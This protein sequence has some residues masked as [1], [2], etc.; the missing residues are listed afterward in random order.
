MSHLGGSL[1]YD[2]VAVSVLVTVVLLTDGSVRELAAFFLL[3][4]ICKSPYDA[5]QARRRDRAS[6][7][8]S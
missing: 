5:W 7:N 6:G 8:G 2:L 3:V 4:T 1:L